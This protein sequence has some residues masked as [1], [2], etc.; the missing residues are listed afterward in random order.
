MFTVG[1][2]LLTLVPVWAFGYLPYLSG[3]PVVRVSEFCGGNLASLAFEYSGSRQ[4]YLFR[5]DNLSPQWCT[6]GFVVPARSTYGTLISIHNAD[7]QSSHTIESMSVAS[8]YQLAGTV[9]PLPAQILAGAN[10]TVD[11]TIRVPAVP[12]SYGLPSATVSAG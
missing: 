4:G 10:L 8:P 3:P 11:L 6:T 5:A 9:P 7:L 1:V 2:A 12:G